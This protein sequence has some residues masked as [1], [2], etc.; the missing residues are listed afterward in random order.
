MKRKFQLAAAVRSTCQVLVLVMATV[1]FASEA[2]VECAE[3]VAMA[4][5]A[6]ASGAASQAA[7]DTE[8]EAKPSDDNQ[9][10]KIDS[11]TETPVDAGSADGTAASDS[12]ANTSEEQPKNA[13]A[14]GNPFK[15]KM[16]FQL[17][18]VTQ[19]DDR[20]G[21]PLRPVA[22][23][24]KYQYSVGS[25][26]D[27]T[28][29]PNPELDNRIRDRFVVFAPQIN[30][31]ILYRPYDWVETMLEM[32]LEREISSHEESLITLPNG[33]T[34][35]AERRRGSLLVDQAFV[36]FKHLGPFEV[37]L[38]RKNF[39][40]QR[41][42]LY[43][44]SLDVALVKF[45][46]GHFQLEASVGRKDM[47]DLDLL[48]PVQETRIDNHMLYL[49]Y[50]GIED[51]RLAG[52]AIRRDDRRGQEG[53]PLHLGLRANGTPSD[54][55]TFWAELALLRGKDE[56]QQNFK[57]HAVDFGGTYRLRK[58]PL[59]PAITLGYAFGS[60]DG[61]PTDNVN[62]EFRQTGLQSNEAKLAGFSKFK[63]YGE[64]LDP[65]LSNLEILTVGL[66][67]RP[68]PTV[69]VDLVYHRYRLNEISDR[70][71][72]SPVTALMNQDDAHLGKDVGKAIDIVLGFRNMFGVHRLGLDLRAGWFFPNNIFRN[73]AGSDPNNPVFRGADNGISALAKFWW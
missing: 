64:V 53:K 5:L 34:R 17:P 20:L 12:A 4:A 13:P 10:A 32:I 43:D 72:K 1:V 38:G 68:A 56:L 61:N 35:V 40:D 26:S 15:G 41:H 60:G 69:F 67:L 11:G 7:R 58:L 28:Y 19:A 31:Y 23:F 30:G 37:T 55:F 18:P 63:Y 3:C 2:E 48:R 9:P 27:I 22:E 52:Y 71:R 14:A 42:W 36:T 50:R 33:E 66:G 51:I 45:K 73:D 6:D 39:E 8:V 25:E 46:Q 29:R 24:L 57:A 21:R 44:T 59:N 54:S 62:T 16:L 65:D 49:D 70:I 47:V